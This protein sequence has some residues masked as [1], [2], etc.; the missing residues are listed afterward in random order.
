MPC[1]V[2][3]AGRALHLR[4]EP[5]RLSKSRIKRL[6]G[7]DRPQYCLR[8]DEVKVFRSVTKPAL[9]PRLSRSGSGSPCSISM[10]PGTLE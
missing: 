4:H 7:L 6:R 10:T 1:D 3:L 5:K 9:H 8:I 2:S